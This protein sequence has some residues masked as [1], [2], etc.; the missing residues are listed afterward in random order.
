FLSFTSLSLHFSHTPSLRQSGFVCLR[1][2]RGNIIA[3]RR[4]CYLITLLFSSSK[5]SRGLSPFIELLH[6]TFFPSYTIPTTAGLLRF[7]TRLIS[8]FSFL[9]SLHIYPESFLYYLVK[10]FSI[11][12]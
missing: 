6:D 11:V 4:V 7:P 2:T 5:R 12:R 9:F 10:S 8:V 3:W 1:T